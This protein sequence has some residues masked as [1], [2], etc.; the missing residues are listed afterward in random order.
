M[1][2]IEDSANDGGQDRAI[3]DATGGTAVSTSD[4]ANGGATAIEYQLT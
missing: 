3:D 1:G 4:R 2:A